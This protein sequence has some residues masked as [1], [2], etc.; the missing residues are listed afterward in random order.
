MAQFPVIDVVDIPDAKL[1]S[2]EDRAAL[3]SIGGSGGPSL[4]ISLEDTTDSESRLAMTVVEREKLAQVSLTRGALGDAHAALTDNPHAVTAAQVGAPTT[5]QFDALS[6]QVDALS[7]GAPATIEHPIYLIPNNLVDTNAAAAL[8]NWGGGN[9]FKQLVRL[10]DAKKLRTSAKVNTAGIAG[11]EFTVAWSLDDVTY[12]EFPG[13]ALSV[14]SAGHKWMTTQVDVP[15]EAKAQ[16][17]V[18]VAAMGKGGDGTAASSAAVGQGILWLDDAAA[19]V[20][21]GGGASLPVSLADTTDSVAGAGRLALTTAERA[22][23]V[24]VPGDTGGALAA[25]AAQSSLDS[26]TAVVA[27]KA[28]A[29]EVTAALNTKA[30]L[31]ATTTA[32]GAK[33]SL[34]SPA[35]TGNMTVPNPPSNDN[36]N[37]PATTSFVK[38]QPVNAHTHPIADVAN[39]AAELANLQAQINAVQAGGVTRATMNISGTAAVSAA[40]A[41]VVFVRNTANATINMDQP[42]SLVST[43]F[44]LYGGANTAKFQGGGGN[45]IQGGAFT[46]ASGTHTAPVFVAFVRDPVT[47]TQWNRI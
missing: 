42:T 44:V 28:V 3:D 13:V 40:Q 23:L 18:W 15:A 2:D 35:F 36:S 47:P 7:G 37:R 31:V 21:G 11:Q 22:K 12:T 29:S 19:V 41:S 33:A 9:G 1:L 14:A 5:T 45:T 20:I 24:N 26:L 32:L 38:G 30:D 10:E 4:P 46:V 27:T 17:R 43:T 34:D 39:L 8:H 25:K 16:E 6:A